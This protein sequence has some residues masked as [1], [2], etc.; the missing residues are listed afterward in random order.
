MGPLYWIF[1]LAVFS[2]DP[3]AMVRLTLSFLWQNTPGGV[4]T[5]P[6]KVA[7]AAEEKRSWLLS[8]HGHALS[9]HGWVKPVRFSMVR[10]PK[11]LRAKLR[12]PSPNRFALEQLALSNRCF[13]P[14][15]GAAPISFAGML[16]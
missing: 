1:Q 10:C 2:F 3:M 4:S 7:G 11:R 13:L 5:K 9:K 8:H 12:P 16:Q 14:Q 6:G 15:P